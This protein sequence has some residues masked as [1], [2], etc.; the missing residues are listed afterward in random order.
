MFNFS[1]IF[2]VFIEKRAKSAS[3][4]ES[5]RLKVIQKKVRNLCKQSLEREMNNPNGYDIKASCY[6]IGNY[7]SLASDIEAT[8]VRKYMRILNKRVKRAQDNCSYAGEYSG[9]RATYGSLQ[10]NLNEWYEYEL[11]RYSLSDL[12]II[13]G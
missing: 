7:A 12:K 9:G 4:I 1:K 3:H 2:K 13:V 5:L 10:S 6:A 8:T 11:R